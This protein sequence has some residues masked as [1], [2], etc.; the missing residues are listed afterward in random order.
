MT[1]GGGVSGLGVIYKVLP[2]G[3]NYSV[4]M[5]FTGAVNGSRPE[6][7]F[8]YDGT[9][10]YGMTSTG[11]TSDLGTLFKIKTDGTGYVKLKDFTG[12]LNGSTPKGTLIYDGTFLYGITSLGGAWGQGDIF[13]IKPD[14]T[15][16][17]NLYGFNTSIGLGLKGSLCTD[18][19]HLYGMTNSGGLSNKGIIFKILP[20]GTGFST[21]LNFNGALNGANPLGSLTF[22]GTYLYGMTENGGSS[23][24]GVVFKI[25]P[26]GTGYV[27]LNDFTGIIN[28]SNPKG[29][30]IFNGTLLY[31][32]TRT[33]GSSNSGTIFNITPSG[34]YTK[35]WNFTGGT[36]GFPTGSLYL[37]GGDLYGMT[38]SGGPIGAANGTIFKYQLITTDINETNFANS[39]LISPN[40]SNGQI[41]IKVAEITGS[42]DLSV[43]NLLGELVFSETIKEKS[44]GINLNLKTGLYFVSLDNKGQKA[45]RKIIVE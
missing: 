28:G 7:S 38:T 32:M 43:H 39:F 10:L 15:G 42:C 5:N 33:G 35:L 4:L 27:K 22:D 11:G 1:N 34:T 25:L 9:Y 3:T 2:D 44:T 45:I 19:T 24:S 36:G 13:K 20:D 41:T 40:P 16:Y 14:G 6:G 18:G 12:T 26:N 8:T 21:L 31:G 23:G 17:T 37:N 30:L 29:S